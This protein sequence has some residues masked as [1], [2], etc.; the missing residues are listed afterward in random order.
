ME[1][2][3][4]ENWKCHLMI[5]QYSVD[6]GEEFCLYPKWFS[7]NPVVSPIQMLHKGHQYNEL[8]GNLSPS[9]GVFWPQ[10]VAG[11]WPKARISSNTKYNWNS[12]NRYESQLSRYQIVTLLR[13]VLHEQR[14][15]LWDAS[16]AGIPSIQIPS[17]ITEKEPGKCVGKWESGWQTC[18]PV[19][20]EFLQRGWLAVWCGQWS[21]TSRGSQRDS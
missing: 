13:P 15:V 9:S 17:C 10:L 14:T 5:G 8:D 18:N 20:Q 21:Q 1:N 19:P 2:G 11:R 6:N 3:I 12:S 16:L 7:R 4:N